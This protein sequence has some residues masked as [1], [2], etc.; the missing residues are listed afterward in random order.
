V[1]GIYAP[2]IVNIYIEALKKELL[3]IPSGTTF[4]TL[5]IGG[6]TPTV[7]PA[8]IL[9]GFIDYIFNHSNFIEHYEATI[10]ANPGTLNKEKLQALYSSGIN[11]ISIGVQSFNNNE[12]ALLGRLH[13]SKEAEHALNIVKE[14]GFKNI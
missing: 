5:Y 11:R 9:S 7:L 1:S 6:G 8:N 3:S 10:E 12:L 13:T 14:S 4:S 2:E